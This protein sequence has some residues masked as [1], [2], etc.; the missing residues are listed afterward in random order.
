MFGTPNGKAGSKRAFVLNIIKI[1]TPLDLRP[2]LF[3]PYYF[4]FF[5]ESRKKTVFF[6]KIPP[7]HY[8]EFYISEKSF[9]TCNRTIMNNEIIFGFNRADKL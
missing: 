3:F 4:F 5:K 9:A 6:F 7:K 8:V 1:I 2:P